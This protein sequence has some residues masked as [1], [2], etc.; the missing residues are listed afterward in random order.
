MCGKA[1]RR[2]LRVLAGMAVLALVCAYPGVPAQETPKKPPANEQEKKE[3]DEVLGRADVM[4]SAWGSRKTHLFKGN[5][6]FTHGDTVLTSDL[7]EYD[8]DD[9]IA[10]SPGKINITNPECDI[11]G[12]KGAAYFKK[13]L[14]VIEG[15]V[16]MLLKPKK[17]G[18]TATDKDSIASELKEPTT[19]T[20]PKLEYLYKAKTATA[21]G[22]VIF[23]QTK[24][25]A[26]AE[27][28]VYDQNKELLTL[29][30]NVKG[31]DEHGQTFSA[32]GKVVISLKKGD[33][34]MEAQNVSASFKIDLEEEE[35]E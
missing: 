7:I 11:S 1:G 17:T 22:G 29:I 2:F 27:K 32:P 9:Q 35:K 24:R 19:I 18:E 34:W 3:R 26:S 15:N 6:R 20:C 12:D 25:S 5:V 8:Q 10:V 21:N 23:K 31:K 14:G 4:K 28:A 30:G 33:E 16:V 13:K